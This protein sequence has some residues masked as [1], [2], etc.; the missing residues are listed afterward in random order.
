MSQ[1]YCRIV[2]VAIQSQDLLDEVSSEVAGANV[3][4][5]GTTRGITAGTKTF[6]I[7]YECHESM[8]FAIL[9]SLRT[10]AVERFELVHCVIEH[11]IGLVHVGEISVAIA[12]SAVHRKEAFDAAQWIME[13][14]KEEVP[15]WKCEVGHD[16]NRVWVHPDAVPGRRL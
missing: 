1:S 7:D 8:A 6:A 2:Q 16:G 12:T 5:V 9:K 10:K 3:L 15:I 14:I 4:F 13:R 11:R